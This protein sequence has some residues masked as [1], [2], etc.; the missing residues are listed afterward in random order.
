MNFGPV[1]SYPGYFCCMFLVNKLNLPLITVIGSYRYGD[2][3]TTVHISNHKPLKSSNIRN[4]STMV[5]GY[6]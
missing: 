5:I 2:V 3:Y 6:P 4:G 1:R